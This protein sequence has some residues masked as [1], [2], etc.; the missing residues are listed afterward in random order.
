MGSLFYSSLVARR[1]QA[2][3]FEASTAVE[4]QPSHFQ[5]QAGLVCYYNSHK[6]HYLYISC[7]EECGRHLGIMSCPAD[8]SLAAEYPLQQ[9]PVL[10]NGV[11]TVFLRASVRR[12]T[13]QFY[14]SEDGN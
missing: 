11:G 9:A 13:L 5:Q 10:L 7:D 14:W 1:Q 3:D 4:Y 2:F 6:F 12:A 8:L